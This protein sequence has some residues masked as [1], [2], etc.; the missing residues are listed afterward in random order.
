MKAKTV[1]EVIEA[2]R[3]THNITIANKT[4]EAEKMIIKAQNCEIEF[5]GTCQAKVTIDGEP[6]NIDN[7]TD[8]LVVAELGEIPRLYI[9]FVIGVNK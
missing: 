5:S 4:I 8:F 3:A 9:D 7:A 1:A 6:M 2:F